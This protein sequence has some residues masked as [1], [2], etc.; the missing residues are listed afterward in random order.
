[1]T[2]DIQPRPV[3]AMQDLRFVVTIPS[4]S[5]VLE[6]PLIQLSMPAMN[7]GNNLV[8]LKMRAPDVY[9][10]Q[11]IIMRCRSGRRTWCATLIIPEIGTLDFIFDVI[12]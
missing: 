1:M 10:G 6:P 12:Y 5:P 4:R 3:K 9:E 7:M 2:L 8:K 11:G